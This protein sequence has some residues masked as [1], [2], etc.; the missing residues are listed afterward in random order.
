M[1]GDKDLSRPIFEIS[2]VEIGCVRE[3]ALSLFCTSRAIPVADRS[4][5]GTEAL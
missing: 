1:S 3:R 2:G 5:H 4:E